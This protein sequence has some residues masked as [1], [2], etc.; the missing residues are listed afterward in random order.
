MA[1][2]FQQEVI[3]LGPATKGRLTIVRDEL[4]REKNRIVTYD[5]A[6]E[7]LLDYR[8]AVTAIEAGQ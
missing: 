2:P 3:K 1:N 6:V 5:A 8:D 7:Y 4:A